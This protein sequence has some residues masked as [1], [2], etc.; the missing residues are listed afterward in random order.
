MTLP[1]NE[2]VSPF[3]RWAG[4]K[5]WLIKY[6]DKFLPTSFNNYYELFVGGASIFTHLVNEKKICNKVF[7]SD[8]NVDL[9]NTY[10]SIRDNV[11]EV[12]YHLE[13]FKNSKAFYYKLRAKT[14][15][16]KVQRAARFIYLNR[17]S[18]N[19]IYRENLKGEYNVPYGYKNYKC[20]FD[21]NN[22]RTFSEKLK[23]V[24]LYHRDFETFIENIKQNDLV[25]L[26]P[27]YTVAHSNNGFIKYNQQLFSIEDQ[28]RLA[29][30]LK[31]IKK[32]KAYFIL[33]NASH[34]NIKNIFQEFDYKKI[35]RY[36]V[37]GGKNSKREKIEELIFFNTVAK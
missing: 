13:T 26:D 17:T 15:I 23:D 30:F 16:D 37:V 2:N 29:N 18:F 24:N 14:F 28:E 36:S 33:T 31:K 34:R 4:G 10:A 9:I 5:N 11:E 27:P 35:K 8:K 32:R 21:Y 20:L 7:L 1:K 19:G 22:L 3:L 6:I 25:F 12:I